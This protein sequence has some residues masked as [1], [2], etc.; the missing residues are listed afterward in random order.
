MIV[1]LSIQPPAPVTRMDA[2]PLWNHQKEALLHVDRTKGG[3]GLFMDMGTGKSRVVV[4]YLN[5]N[6]VSLVLILCPLSVVPAW[7]KQFDLYGTKPFLILPM[8]E[9]WTAA[10]KRTEAEHAE[11]IARARRLPLVL[12]INYES[13]W[14]PPLGQIYDATGERVLDPGYFLA[15]DWDVVCAD[16]LH[17]CKDPQGRAS[18]FL[19]KLGEQAHKRIGLT[20]TPMPHSP[21]DLFAQYRF[22]DPSIF[23]R[24]YYAFKARYAIMGGFEGKEV[25]GWNHKDEMH[26]R[27]MSLAYRVRA[28]DVLDL[29][30]ATHIERRCALEASAARQYKE[31]WKNFVVETEQGTVTAANAMV[32]LLR[33]QQLTSGYLRTEEGEDVE[34][35]KAKAGLLTEIFTDLP[36]DEPVVVFCR[37]RAD[38]DTVRQMAE[39]TDRSVAELSGRSNQLA[40]WQ[41]GNR[42]VLAVQI[43]AGGVGIDLSRA[44]YAVYY[45][46]GF[47]LG[48]YE[49]SVAR[50]HR[51]G[52]A[53]P[54]FYYHLICDGTVDEHVYRALQERRDVIE[55]ILRDIKTRRG[56]AGRG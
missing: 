34:V 25:V 33:L 44:H 40:D 7:V 9:N 50:L 17:R 13:A 1:P 19:A 31:M 32:K 47:S 20:G 30:P 51:P 15:R 42:T 2:P 14:R 46:L 21:L 22:L 16:E 41:A 26:Q 10:R 12:I 4:E 28:A 18:R 45:S 11:A 24:S 27:M 6:H 5:R 55:S 29:P 23:G 8:K 53:H 35:S 48:E 38:L 52:Q 56:M 36:T 54:V 3:V 49:Q 37:F 43:Q 39:D